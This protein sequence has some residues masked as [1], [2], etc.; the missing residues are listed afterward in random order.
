MAVPEQTPYIEY[1]GNGSTKNFSLTFDC[2]DA[3]HLIVKLNDSPAVTGWV[4]QNDSVVFTVAPAAGTNVSIQ[5]NTPLSRTASYGQYDNSFRPPAINKDFD[6]IWLKLQELKVADWLLSQGIASE[7]VARIA[8]DVYWDQISLERDN[9][10]KKYVNNILAGVTGQP[11]FEIP[12]S[13]IDV[14]QPYPGAVV[15][16]QRDKNNDHI[17]VKDFGAKGDGVTDDRLAIQTAI[18]NTE[19]ALYFP[20]GRYLING[21]LTV[22][23]NTTLRGAG[24][25]STMLVQAALNSDTILV[26]QC[27]SVHIESIGFDSVTQQT[28]GAYIRMKNAHNVR[29]TDFFVDY[30]AH[31]SIYMEGG[32][33]QFMYYV[34]NFEINS[35]K[36]GIVIGKDAVTAADE[37]LVQDVFISTGVIANVKED[38]FLLQ[39]VSGLNMRDVDVISADG[40][41]LTTMPN[42]YGRCVAMTFHNV[43]LDSCGKNGWNFRTNGGIVAE[44]TIIYGWGSTNGLKSTTPENR[45]GIYIDGS[46]DRISAINLVGCRTMNNQG[47][48]V[49]LGR[50]ADVSIIG[51]HSLSNSVASPAQNHGLYVSPNCRNWNVSGGVF[52]NT[53][54]NFQPNQG[55]GIFVDNTTHPHY[56][57]IGANLLHN[58]T[59]ALNDPNTNNTARTIEGNTGIKTKAAGTAKIPSTQSVCVV[60]HGLLYK[61]KPE[62]IQ[63]LRTVADNSGGGLWVDTATITDTTFTVRSSANVPVDTWFGWQANVFNA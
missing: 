53:G 17:S 51:H 37:A 60:A 4:L 24:R 39:Q 27:D 45:N 49:F 25:K 40:H 26:Q 16:T 52:G 12:D 3:A 35:G 58:L 48:G 42:L 2:E 10:L 20:A 32:T 5:R 33:Q 7:A 18:D 50:C 46:T 54:L 38:A 13:F 28:G 47:N 57:I 55:F 61:L 21:T 1:T 19:G 63:I 22:K 8:A 23:H 30:R 15:R 44:V 36:Y 6:K 29:V 59:G 31:M 34:D 41:G 11:I 9:D 43:Q 62:N 14:K 56:S